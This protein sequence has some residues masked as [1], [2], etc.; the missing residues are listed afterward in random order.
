[1]YKVVLVSAKLLEH[2]GPFTIGSYL[3]FVVNL[4]LNE[5]WNAIMS[6]RLQ[7]DTMGGTQR[8]TK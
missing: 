5:Y 7:E 6:K 2:S 8:E 4:F 1:M 3:P